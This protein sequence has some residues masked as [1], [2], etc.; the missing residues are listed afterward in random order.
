[1]NGST[2]QL[3]MITVSLTFG[4][5]VARVLT[6]L[7]ETGDM[8]LVATFMVASSLNAVL[9]SQILYYWNSGA[10]STSP[11]SGAKGKR[12]RKGRKDD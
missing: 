1:M 9:F 8:L 7:Q 4:G 2:G 12:T 10:A 5:S 11:Q 6:S 3:S